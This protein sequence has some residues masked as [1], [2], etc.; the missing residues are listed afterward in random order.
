MRTSPIA[1]A[2]LYFSIGCLLVFFAI[3]SVSTSGWNIWS[4]L[5]ISFAAI[6][7]MIALRFYRLRKVIKQIQNHHKKKDD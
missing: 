6:D 2:L 5:I 4:Y 3:Q 7:F 1:M